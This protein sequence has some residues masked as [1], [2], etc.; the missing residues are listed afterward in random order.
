MGGGGGGRGVL[1][2]VGRLPPGGNKV[3]GLIGLVGTGEERRIDALVFP[4]PPHDG[5]AGGHEL[6]TIRENDANATD[7]AHLVQQVPP[8]LHSNGEIHSLGGVHAKV[9]VRLVEGGGE[10]HAVETGRGFCA[11]R[12]KRGKRGAKYLSGLI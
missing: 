8:R 2:V 4:P 11:R 5:E 9:E 10:V 7:E 6:P 3:A 12:A 1:P